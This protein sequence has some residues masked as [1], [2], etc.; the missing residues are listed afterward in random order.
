MAK[1]QQSTASLKEQSHSLE[2]APAAGRQKRAHTAPDAAGEAARRCAWLGGG[3]GWGLEPGS[4]TVR[5][6]LTC[7]NRFR[8]TGR[9]LTNLLRLR[10]KYHRPG[11]LNNTHFFL[12]L[13]KAGSLSSS[14]EHSWFLLRPLLLGL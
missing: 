14:C 11:G 1:L 10:N 5:V 6:G 4:G 12:T 13:L 7:G 8:P 3:G 2:A 9:A